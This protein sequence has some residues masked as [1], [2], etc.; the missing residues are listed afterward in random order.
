MD[1]NNGT[2]LYQCTSCFSFSDVPI[3]SHIDKTIYMECNCGESC[4]PVLSPADLIWG[5]KNSEL[6]LKEFILKTAEPALILA[7]YDY[8]VSH[9]PACD[10]QELKQLKI[11]VDF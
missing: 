8:P 5:L 7:A 3:E 4:K 1:N 9:G 6:K 2:V 10:L 11:K